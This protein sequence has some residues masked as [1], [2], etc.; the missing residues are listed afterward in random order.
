MT[1]LSQDQ[2]EKYLSGL[3]LIE[4]E[5]LE[6]KTD[7]FFGDNP[8]MLDYMIWP[9]FERY[10]AFI[11]LVPQAAWPAERFPALVDIINEINILFKF[12]NLLNFS[13]H[14]SLEWK[15]TLQ[16]VPMQFLL[17]LIWNTSRA[18]KPENP[19]MIFL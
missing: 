3:D 15:T 4:K 2:L 17:I 14:G 13:L 7:F 9:W 11:Q 6:R 10:P 1:E 5:L 19:I 16:F 8:G 12:A 18:A